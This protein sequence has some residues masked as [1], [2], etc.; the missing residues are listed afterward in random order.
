MHFREDRTD[1][2]LLPS[3]ARHC[4]LAL[5]EVNYLRA[6]EFPG[7]GDI[8]CFV[9]KKISRSAVMQQTQSATSASVIAQS[10]NIVLRIMGGYEFLLPLWATYEVGSLAM[11]CYEFDSRLMR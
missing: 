10:G 5:P 3:F 2:L 9:Y 7:R 4:L 6:P 8:L 1:S 11:G